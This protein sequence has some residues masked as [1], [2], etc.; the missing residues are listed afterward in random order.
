MPGQKIHVHVDKI[1]GS[2]RVDADFRV[3]EVQHVFSQTGFLTAL[4]VTSDVTNAFPKTAPSLAGTLLKYT[5]LG[6]REAKN[7]K[8]QE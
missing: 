2:Y 1:N 5:F 3:T 8:A 7:L 6:Y 4:N